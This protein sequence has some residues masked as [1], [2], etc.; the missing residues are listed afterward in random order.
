MKDP[1]LGGI[2]GNQSKD[3]R[4]D[5]QNLIKQNYLS[6]RTPHAVM[7]DVSYIGPTPGSLLL[8]M[9]LAARLVIGHCYKMSPL[10]TGDVIST[11]D[12]VLY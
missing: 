9:D 7:L 4:Q 11:L 6:T 3:N 1:R 8:V 12:E 2:E 10:D 5:Q